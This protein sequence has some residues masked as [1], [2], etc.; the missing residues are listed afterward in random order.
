MRNRLLSNPIPWLSILI[1]LHRESLQRQ[2]NKHRKERLKNETIQ[3]IGS[4]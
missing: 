1:F 4:H 2:N 3:Q